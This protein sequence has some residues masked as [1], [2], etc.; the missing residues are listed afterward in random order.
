MY[1]LTYLPTSILI[2]E[3]FA[4]LNML[5]KCY[6][7]MFLILSLQSGMNFLQC[8]NKYPLIIL[9]SIFS[10]LIQSLDMILKFFFKTTQNIFKKDVYFEHDFGNKFEY[11]LT[12]VLT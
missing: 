3:F 12:D 5:H 2:F 1:L 4:F 11:L 9:T 7:N 10:P 8:G 6:I